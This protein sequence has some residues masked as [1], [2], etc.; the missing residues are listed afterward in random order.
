[1]GYETE[2]KLRE[3]VR[4]RTGPL[5]ASSM[6]MIHGSE[7]HWGSRTV[8]IAL[9]WFQID[10]EVE[11]SSQRDKSPKELRVSRH[12]FRQKARPMRRWGRRHRDWIGILWWQYGG[13]CV[14]FSIYSQIWT[15][16]SNLNI[17]EKN[18]NI[19]VPN[20]LELL[21]IITS[22]IKQ[23]VKKYTADTPLP[24]IKEINY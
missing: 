12:C 8:L 22:F 1:M 23:L 15:V 4:P 14:W 7:A 17:Y 13:P 21:I 10:W 24:K 16:R 18:L 6:P 11:E 20:P 19:T 9:D 2:R 5:P 3:R